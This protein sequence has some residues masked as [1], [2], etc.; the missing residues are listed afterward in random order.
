MTAKGGEGG[1]SNSE[2]ALKAVVEAVKP[3]ALV[4]A[5]AKPGSFDEGVLRAMREVGL[6]A[7]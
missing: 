4:G 1:V 5:A 6:G 7:G 2:A 3:G